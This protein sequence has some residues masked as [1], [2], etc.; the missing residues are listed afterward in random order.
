VKSIF[1][2]TDDLDLS[3]FK[4]DTEFIVEHVALSRFGKL[5][6]IEVNHAAA[7]LKEH[8]F[9]VSLEWDILMSETVFSKKVDILNQID[10]F[11]FD[12]IRAQ[13]P[14]AI[15]YVIDKLECHISLILE[16][17]NHNLVGIQNWIDHCQG[18]VDRVI[19]SVELDKK[20]LSHY[21]QS[22]ALPIEFLALGRIL[23]FY[24]PRNLL[25]A[26]LPEDDEKKKVRL[27]S[28]D[29]LTA[30][31]ESEESPHKGFPLVENTHGT[32]MFHI[33]RLNLLDSLND[34]DN[35]GISIVRVDT[36]FEQD[37]NIDLILKT[38]ETRDATE[39]KAAY[40]FDSIRGYFNINKT[41]VLFKKLKN[42]RLQRKDESYV[43]EVLETNKGNYM[44][45]MIR[46]T[47]LKIGDELKFI[48]PEG[49]TMECKVYELKNSRGEEISESVKGELCLMNYF[50]SVWPKSQVYLR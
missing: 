16:T 45:I 17:G 27:V 15:E 3:L 1:Y 6:T 14:G 31:G 20:T 38:L 21:S 29:F 32:F 8:G 44:A 48:T 50:G 35:C 37:K 9:K 19:L 39:F 36:R 10:L 4:Q 7:K 5:N 49:K 40:D 42:S 41:D 25:S 24:T 22:L 2:Y 23:I 11:H 34:L 47:S 12:S 13:D 33:K 28:N 43:G 30:T 18:R 26:L 46:K